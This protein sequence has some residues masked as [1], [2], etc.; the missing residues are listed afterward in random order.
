[1]E[2]KPGYKQ[3]DVGVI[4]NDWEICTIGRAMQLDNGFAFKPEDWGDRGLPIIRIQN[5]N[6]P[7]AKFNCCE[8]RVPER[9]HVAPGDLL[10]AWSGTT[11]TS[12]GARIWSGPPGILNQHIFRVTSDA[13]RLT[14]EFSLLVLHRVQGDI[15][16]QAHGFKTSFV[17]VKKSDLVRIALPI[18]PLAEQRAIAGALSDVD[19]LIGALD[20][21]LAKKRDLKQAAMQQLLTGH[22]RLPGFAPANP[23][24]QQTDVGMIPEDWNAT[25]L[26]L[27]AFFKTGP[28]GSSL[29]KSDYTF[30]GVPVI[31]PMHIE[32]GTLQPTRSMTITAEAAR[33]LVDFQLRAEDV[34]IG[35]RGEMGRCAVVRKMHDG[36]LCGTGSLII[37]PSG[38]VAA[39]FLQR[40]L[41]SPETTAR[42]EDASV[43]T[44]MTN[45]NHNVLSRL[46]IQLPSLAE[47][48]AIAEVLSDMDAELA[49]LEQKRDKTRLLKQGMMQELLTGR[50]RLI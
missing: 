18:P 50:T 49:A 39:G 11:G 43:G 41:S 12:F 32:N 26:G 28:F 6:D 13:H 20:Q 15:E 35:R 21:L 47:Q 29:H 5:L 33:H 9:Y 37:R 25:P 36:W 42:I 8:R 30:D 1:M 24:F 19:A 17:H 2:L 45:L 22:Q 31:N 38:K 34:I 23:R 27:V 48:T 40:V 46:L 16:K 10:F 4:P 44:T 7:D 14:P 3:T